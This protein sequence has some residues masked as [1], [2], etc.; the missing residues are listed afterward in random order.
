MPIG[1]F[2]SCSVTPQYG[3]LKKIEITPSGTFLDGVFVDDRYNLD[4]LGITGGE[5]VRFELG[6]KETAVH[7]G[8][9]NL[10]GKNFGDFNQAIIMTIK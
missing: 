5:T 2:S 4:T 1:M 9:I 3:L 6:I 8:G 10:F 7:R